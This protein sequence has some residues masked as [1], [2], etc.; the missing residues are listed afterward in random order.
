LDHGA[1]FSVDRKS[2]D[3][4]A[5]RALAGAG[6]REVAVV[7]ATVVARHV[8]SQLA[9]DRRWC[10]LEASRDLSHGEPLPAQRRDPLPLELREI[11]PAAY[12]LRDP[13]WRAAA[14]LGSPSLAGLATDSDPPTCLQRVDP[15]R[16][17]AQYSSSMPS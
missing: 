16:M 1:R 3:A 5:R 2:S 10:P 13:K 8:A 6:V 4:S 17:S 11:A 7:D 15:P 9:A 14:E 12:R